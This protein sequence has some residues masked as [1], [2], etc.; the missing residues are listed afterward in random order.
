[1]HVRRRHKPK[2]LLPM[3]LLGRTL[4]PWQT[5]L[6]AALHAVN[7]GVACTVSRHSDPRQLV[8]AIRKVAAGETWWKAGIERVDPSSATLLTSDR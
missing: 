3:L 6:A 2:H 4:T 8:E 5:A 1:M 7:P